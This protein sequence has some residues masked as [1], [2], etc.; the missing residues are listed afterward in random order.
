MEIEEIKEILTQ[1]E[2]V[3]DIVKLEENANQP[4]VRVFNLRFSF[5]YR[6]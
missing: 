4:Q 2:Q 5:Y 1:T 6:H 3:P